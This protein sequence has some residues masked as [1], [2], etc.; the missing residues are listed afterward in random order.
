[1][2]QEPPAKPPRLGLLGL[3]TLVFGMMVGSGIFNIPQNLAAGA[4]PAAVMIG[5]GIT[6]IGM[7]LLVTT[8]NILSRSHPELSEGIYLYAEVGF[9]R[10]TGFFVAW[11]YWLCAC[12]ANVAYCVMLNDTLATLCPALDSHSWPTVLFCGLLI[13]GFYFIINRGLRT[14]SIISTL[15]GIVKFAII[16]LIIALLGLNFHYGLFSADIW[17]F[18]DSSVGSLSSQV[19]STMLV[20]LWC[21]IGIEGAVVMAS[22]ARRQSDVGKAGIIGFLSAWVLYVLVSIFAYG[23]MRRAQLAGLDNPSVAYVIN[24]VCGPWAYALVMIS[25]VISITGGLFSWTIV[26][27]EVPYS[28]AR[29]GIFPRWLGRENRSGSPHASLLASA[30]VMQL[31]ILMVVGAE[32]IYLYIL[33]ITGMMIL[34]AYLFS[35][36]FLTKVAASRV[37]IT[38]LLPRKLRGRPLIINGTLQPRS[39]LIVGLGCTLFC[40]WMLY[41]AGLSLLLQS[42]VLFALGLPLFRPR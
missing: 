25:V 41:A 17:S 37:G 6:A 3:S 7:M 18:N 30:I 31:F 24:D 23:I 1:M 4:G 22:R 35:G 12:F 29:H 39:A 16:L 20:T 14:S 33:N 27:A 13:W 36:L 9:N 34:P 5:W 40:L 28:A 15:V 19:E 11:G 8:F 26:T 32:D 42:L 2:K 38:R 10:L 21:F